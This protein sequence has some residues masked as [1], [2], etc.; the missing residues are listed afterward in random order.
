M[1]SDSLLVRFCC[2]ESLAYQADPQAA[3]ELAKLVDEPALRA[4]V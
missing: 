1:R 4:F 3:L 2:S